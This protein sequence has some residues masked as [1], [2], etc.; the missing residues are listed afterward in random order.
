MKDSYLTKSSFT[1][2]TVESG[3]HTKIVA[4]LERQETVFKRTVALKTADQSTR[5]PYLTDSQGNSVEGGALNAN[6]TTVDAV[7]K[8][9]NTL[10]IH[11]YVYGRDFVW[12]DQ[13]YTDD[14]DDAIIIEY[15]DV[16]ILTLLGLANRNG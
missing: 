8:V 1:K 12:Q 9:C 14:L 15:D 16:K 5:T 3:E 4:I 6:Y 13:G 7:A 10:G 11:G 2:R